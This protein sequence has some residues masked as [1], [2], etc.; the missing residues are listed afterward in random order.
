MRK[1]CIL[2]DESLETLN[3]IKEIDTLLIVNQACDQKEK[4]KCCL[5]NIGVLFLALMVLIIN[6]ILIIKMG[7]KTFMII[8]LIL[9]WLITIMF[10]PLFK[11]N[12]IKEV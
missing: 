2:E 12:F 6:L 4:I 3:L 1:E 10:L 7:V 5:K 11:R 8:Q 9:S